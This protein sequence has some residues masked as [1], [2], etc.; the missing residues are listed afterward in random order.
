M[1]IRLWLIVQRDRHINAVRCA[2]SNHGL[3][4]AL[5]RLFRRLKN[6]PHR[7][8]QLAE[9]GGTLGNKA[10]RA[11]EKAGRFVGAFSKATQDAVQARRDRK[12]SDS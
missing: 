12:G 2:G 3:R 4:A 8:A 1:P 7:A 9:L 6:Q 5:W 10:G 11:G